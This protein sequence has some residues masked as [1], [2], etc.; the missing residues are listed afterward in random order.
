VT[1]ENLI[2]AVAPST[3]LTCTNGGPR[4]AASTP[5]SPIGARSKD[6]TRYLRS[7]HTT[8]RP[9]GHRVMNGRGQLRGTLNIRERPAEANDRAVPGHWEGDLLMGKRMHAM[10]TLVERKTRFVMLITLPD[11]HAADIVADALAAK[12]VELPAQL[13]RSITWDQ[14]KEMAAHARFRVKTGVPIY[15]CDPRTPWCAVATRTPTVCSASTSPNAPRSRTTAK[16]ISTTSQQ[17]S[18]IALDKPS[19]G[20]HHHELSTRRCDDHLNPQHIW[21]DPVRPTS[22]LTDVASSRSRSGRW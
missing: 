15:F 17:N 4:Q 10:A 2:G 3:R 21:T 1:C 20:D 11:G 8:R 13:R 16:R 19:D 12:I 14:G 9:R 22:R 7:G 5:G 18:T 6:L